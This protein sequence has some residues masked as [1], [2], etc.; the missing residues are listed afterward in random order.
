MPYCVHCG[1]PLKEGELC[2]CP[3]AQA[4]RAQ[5]SSGSGPDPEFIPLSQETE[6]SGTGPNAGDETPSPSAPAPEEPSGDDAG[7]CA[8]PDNEPAPSPAPQPGPASGPE[9]SPGWQTPDPAGPDTYTFQSDGPSAPP[10]PS[11][12]TITLKNLLPFLKAYCRSPV[13][14]TRS[15][16][17]QADVPMALLLALIQCLAAVLAVAAVL[18]RINRLLVPI[19]DFLGLGRRGISP[20]LSIPCGLLACVLG[21]ACM[22]VLFLALARLMKSQATIRDIFIAC[23]VNTIPVTAVLLLAF[24]LGLLSLPLGLWLLIMVLPFFAAAGL[25][26]AKALCPDL[27][28]GKFWLSYLAGLLLVVGA[29]WFV[30]SSLLF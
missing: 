23:G 20:A 17:S 8:A 4:Q 12:V 9:S 10:K 25:I 22:M 30:V 11:L 6:L 24:L 3:A 15:A 5:L 21:I 1:A 2:S 27:S 14:A 13:E 26:S 29:T 19:L 7:T 28:G 16:V 18:F